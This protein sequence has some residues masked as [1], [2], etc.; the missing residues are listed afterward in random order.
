MPLSDGKRF[1][2]TF[3]D[4][5]PLAGSTAIGA[6]QQATI[7]QM[8]NVHVGSHFHLSGSSHQQIQPSHL[9]SIQSTPAPSV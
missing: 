8:S 1:Q 6:S 4:L 9:E 2:E 3:D 5:K 7:G